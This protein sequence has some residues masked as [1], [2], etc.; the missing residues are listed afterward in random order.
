MDYHAQCMNVPC[1]QGGSVGEGLAYAEGHRDA[2][3][4][5]AAIVVNVPVWTS[6]KMHPADL[7]GAPEADSRMLVRRKTDT[8]FEI[9]GVRSICRNPDK[10]VMDGEWFWF[11]D[12]KGYRHWQ[13][14]EDTD[15]WMLLESINCLAT[16]S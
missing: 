4:A 5:C 11:F 1:K 16:R 10:S 14:I 7:V 6:M 2:R 3:H 8:G 9:L 12:Y 15:E 13:K